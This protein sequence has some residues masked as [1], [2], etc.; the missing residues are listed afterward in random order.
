MCAIQT[1][2]TWTQLQKAS[3]VH[4]LFLLQ[5]SPW[6]ITFQTREKLNY[7]K[8]RNEAVT[9][10]SRPDKTYSSVLST[11]T[12]NPPPAPAITLNENI[13]PE[14]KTKDR[15]RVKS[16][17]FVDVISAKK[18][19]AQHCANTT[20]AQSPVSVQS[21]NIIPS[22]KSSTRIVSAEELRRV[23]DA[24][25]PVSSCRRLH[26]QPRSFLLRLLRCIQVTLVWTPT[27][28]PSLLRAK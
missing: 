4:N 13:A 7:R 16:S 3:L 1:R 21:Q 23:P 24:R 17:D 9:Y 2:S 18:Q 28:V 26:Q 27:F 8:A 12:H 20:I 25:F 19:R 15:K 10:M 14:T 22:Q 5:L 11:P 6:K